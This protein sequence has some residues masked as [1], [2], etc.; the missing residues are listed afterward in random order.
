MSSVNDA[1]EPQIW[2]DTVKPTEPA[3]PVVAKESYAGK[4]LA[5]P[6]TAAAAGTTTGMPAAPVSVAWVVV[7]TEDVWGK[8]PEGG[9]TRGVKRTVSANVEY[10]PPP[11]RQVWRKVAG[12]PQVYF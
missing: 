7:G 9:V 12:Q 5:S 4:R 6:L 8:A 10:Q 11:L 3:R 2:D 1:D